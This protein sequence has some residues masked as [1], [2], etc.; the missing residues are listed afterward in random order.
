VPKA[1]QSVAKIPASASTVRL[2]QASVRLV[3]TASPECG[4]EA[5]R[6]SVNG[7]PA[8]IFARQ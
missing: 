1:L 7:P 6:V 8:Q 5:H 2:V 3:T 4:V